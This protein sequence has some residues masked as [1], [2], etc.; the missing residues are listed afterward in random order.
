MT[1][2]LLGLVIT[3]EP[4]V[5]TTVRTSVALVVP[6]E[7]VAE[8]MILDVPFTPG[9]PEITGEVKLNPGGSEIAPNEVGDPEAVIV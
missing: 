5:A 2:M 3:G 8:I 6:P 1:L 7:F 9:V 4:A